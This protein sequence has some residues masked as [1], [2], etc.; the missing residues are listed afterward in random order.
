ME[1]NFGIPN[2]KMNCG[3]VDMLLLL[4]LMIQVDFGSKIHG[5]QNGMEMDIQDIHLNIGENIGKFLQQ[6]MIQVVLFLMMKN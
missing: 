6:L 2:L 5:E 3:G 1:R 4:L